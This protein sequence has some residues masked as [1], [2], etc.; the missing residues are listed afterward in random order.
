MNIR[1]ELLHVMQDLH[2]DISKVTP[3]TR[4]KDDLDMDSTEIV[5]MAVALEKRLPL[6][7][8][9]AAL[10]KLQTFADVEKFLQAL[11]DKRVAVS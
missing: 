7:I 5:E 4:L 1:A 11:M 8:D 6:T 2:I 3:T 9:D 10:G